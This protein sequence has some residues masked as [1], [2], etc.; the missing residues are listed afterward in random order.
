VM[1]TVPIDP[2][3]ASEIEA[4]EA[5]AWT[6]LY[7]AAPA[8][9]AIAAGLGTSDVDGALV[10]RWAASGRRYFSRTIGVGV[11][12]PA[13]IEAVDEILDAYERA[14]I[15]MF[16]LQSLPQCRPAEYEGWLR[17]RGLEPFDAQDRIVRGAEPLVPPLRDLDGREFVVERVD[18]A[19]ADE[20]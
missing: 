5:R 13:T 10:L 12:M 7:G 1:D 15:S 19:S 20:W 11:F 2:V 4:A 14:A 9:F 17:E 3:A 18:S 8:E 16:L 6:D